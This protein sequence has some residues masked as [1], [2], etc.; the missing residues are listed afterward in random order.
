M[1]IWDLPAGYLNRESL[2]GEHGELHALLSILREG[3]RGFARHPETLRWMGCESG[4]ARRHA[5]LV[6]EMGLRGY[7]DRTPIEERPGEP[8]WPEEFLDLPARQFELLAQR[9]E[10]K[11]GGRILLPR[12]AS[13]LWAQHKY[14]VLA[15]DPETY[16][17]LG[18]RV[19]SDPDG[20]GMAGLARELVHLLRRRPPA[21]PLRN[22]IDHMWGHVEKAAS[23]EER[24][25][26]KRSSAT[27]FA[28]VQRLAL[29]TG[30]PYLKAST[31][32]S[33]LGVFVEGWP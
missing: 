17:E 13:E 10:G 20:E 21:G 25:E 30:E 6:A 26:A 3:K 2:L 22:V 24:E 19:A 29:R 1:R 8:V 28:G 5:L 12:K 9:Y 31:A 16:R 11:A 18:R 33:E 27:R 23:P 14:S 4:L 15:R 32:L 7:V